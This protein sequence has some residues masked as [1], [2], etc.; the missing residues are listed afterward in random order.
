MD[1]ISC[2]RSLGGKRMSKNKK[3]NKNSVWALALLL[4]PAAAAAQG[5]GGN[6]NTNEWLTFGY[7]AQRSGWNSAETTL[8]PANVKRLKPLWNS[9]LPITPQDTS[10]STLPSPL[11]AQVDGKTLL[12]T[13]GIDD[14]LYGLDAD[15]G[16]IVW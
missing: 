5:P 3:N 12:F 13:V 2:R 10:L 1:A 6:A 14:T 16:K 4:I 9:Q 8:S 15:S 11:V 7:D